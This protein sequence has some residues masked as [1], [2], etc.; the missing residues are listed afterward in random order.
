MLR[1]RLGGGMRQAGLLAAACSYALDH[2]V[3]RLAEDHARAAAIADVLGVGPVETNIVPVPV[4]DA[5][6]LAAAAREQGVLVSVVG[7]GRIRLVTHLDVDDAAARR[8]AEVV[9]GLLA[10]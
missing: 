7:P 6:A 10:G 5:P 1:K 3:E 8:A 2:H 4:D 9:A